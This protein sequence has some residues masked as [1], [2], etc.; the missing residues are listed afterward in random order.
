MH[1]L[2]RLVGDLLQLGHDAGVV[3]LELVVDQHHALVGDQRGRV[4]GHEVVVDDVQ[5]VLDLD[6]IQLRRL[7]AELT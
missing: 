7:V 2:D 3:D 1:V 4:A 6:Q 5:I